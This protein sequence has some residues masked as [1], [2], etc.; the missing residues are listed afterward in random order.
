MKKLIIAALAASLSAGVMAAG[1][2][3]AGKGQ[4]CGLVLAVMG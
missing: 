1:D 2:A 3:A 4:S